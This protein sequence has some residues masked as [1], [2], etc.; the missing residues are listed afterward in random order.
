MFRLYF[1]K[2]PA[3]E[4]G[5]VALEVTMAF[6]VMAAQLKPKKA[7]YAHNLSRI[8]D[9]FAQIDDLDRR[10]DVLVLPETVT[11]GYFLEGGVREAARTSETL[12]QDLLRA[13]R[14]R[15]A[16]GDASLDI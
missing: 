5:V 15:T 8:G 4:L 2:A 1:K 12:Y 16:A 10:P 11:T 14:E 9:I 13:Y 3:R 7:D 6:H